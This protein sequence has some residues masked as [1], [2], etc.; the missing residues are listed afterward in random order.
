MS[1]S[2]AF[3][4]ADSSALRISARV[5]PRMISFGGDR[6]PRQRRGAKVRV[7]N[8][9]LEFV[10]GGQE[11]DAAVEIDGADEEVE[12]VDRREPVG[13]L[14]GRPEVLLQV[15]HHPG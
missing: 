9:A 3:G 12:D 4:K 15:D 11:L 7:A 5:G 2:Y 13:E 8:R 1:S 6:A 14:P 10:D